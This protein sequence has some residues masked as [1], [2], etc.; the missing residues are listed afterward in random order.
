MKNLPKEKNEDAEEGKE[1]E[2]EDLKPLYINLGEVIIIM[3]L[4]SLIWTFVLFQ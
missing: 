3:L 4:V 1:N 2:E